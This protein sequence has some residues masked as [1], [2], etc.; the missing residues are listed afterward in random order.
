MARSACSD[1]A[2]TRAAGETFLTLDQVKK[3]ADAC[4]SASTRE[5][6]L[7]AA[8]TGIRRGHLLRL[9]QKD[10]KDGFILLDRTSKTAMLQMVPIHPAVADIASRL[11]LG[12]SDS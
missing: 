4:A 3:L 10:I 1:Q 6:V 7:L 11:P 5:Y 9:T 2:A 8:Y 12:S